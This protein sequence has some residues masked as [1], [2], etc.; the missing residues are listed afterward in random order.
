[1]AENPGLSNEEDQR[2]LEYLL[3]QLADKDKQLKEEAEA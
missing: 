2:Q 1:M 3:K